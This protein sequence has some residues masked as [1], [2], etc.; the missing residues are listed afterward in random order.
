MN[1]A[2]VENQETK[3]NHEEDPEDGESLRVL[4]NQKKRT[5][6]QSKD[7]IYFECKV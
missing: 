2:Q 5:R 7:E 4:L 6:G 1:V 3:I